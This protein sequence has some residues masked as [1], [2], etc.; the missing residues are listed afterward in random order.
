[1]VRIINV[2]AASLNGKI[3][4]ESLESDAARQRL[5]L[6]SSE[7]YAFLC[8]QITQSDAI[9]VGA[10]SIR[11]NGTCLD[12]LG[13]NGTP[14]VWY[15]LTNQELPEDLPFWQQHHVPR[16]IVS[17]KKI[18]IPSSSRAGFLS[19]DGQENIPTTIY[20]DLEKRGFKRALLFG[21]GVVNGW[22]YEK[23]LVD[24]LK[25]TLSPLFIAGV[26]QPELVDSRI[27]KHVRFQLVSSHLAESYVF[28]SYEVLKN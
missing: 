2:M 24:E 9:I 19:A 20:Q 28:L 6:S 15:V 25:L 1:M 26:G 7:D 11:A 21:G 12:V 16:V 5:G 14:P 27:T 4:G 10:T 23:G 3:G 13:K 17:T 18:T 8:D 22:F